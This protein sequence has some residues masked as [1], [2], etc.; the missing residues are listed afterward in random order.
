MNKL[1]VILIL[2]FSLNFSLAARTFDWQG[3][4]GARGLYP[5][6]TIEGMKQALKFPIQTLEMDVV[7]SADRQVVVSHEPWMSE[8]ICLDSNLKP[9]SN[10]SIN[11]FKLKY[12]EISKYDCGSKIHPRFNQQQKKKESKP[13]LAALISELEKT[14]KKKYSIEIKSTDDDENLGFQPNF[15]EFTDLVLKVILTHLGPDQFMIQSFDWRVLNYIFEF[16]PQIK[17]VALIEESYEYKTILKK[18]KKSPTVFSPDYKFLTKDQ[19]KH[20]HKENVLVIPWTVNDIQSMNQ[21]ISL[22]V[23]GLIT[24]YPNLIPLAKKQ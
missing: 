14:G 4:R 1:T 20:F 6:N 17:T 16:Y 11:I 19:V 24:D 2:S 9:V 10:R 12:D 23:D 15:K 22:G 21:L 8:E 3:H 13:L 18:L 7:I 5:E